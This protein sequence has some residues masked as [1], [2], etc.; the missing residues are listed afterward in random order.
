LLRR[1]WRHA[2]VETAAPERPLRTTRAVIYVALAVLALFL[3]RLGLRA[4][5]LAGI[6]ASYVPVVGAR[7]NW[8]WST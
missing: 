8:R 3:G 2:G 7:W 6:G 4:F 5:S 1:H